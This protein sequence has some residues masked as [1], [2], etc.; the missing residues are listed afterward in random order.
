MTT[1]G[2]DAWCVTWLL[3]E[4]SKSRANPPLPRDPTTSMSASFDALI[5]KSES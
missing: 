5:R 1:T 4:P 2:Q 3:T